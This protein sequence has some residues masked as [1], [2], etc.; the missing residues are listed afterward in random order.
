[1]SENLKKTHLITLSFD[2]G[3]KKSFYKTAEIYEQYGLKA[4]FNVVALGHQPNFSPTI[5]GQ[6]DPGFVRFPKGNFTDW[7]HLKKRGHEVM[8]HT[9]NHVNLTQIPLVEAKELIDKCAD[10]F[11]AHLQGFNVSDSVYSFA[12][13]A[14]NP[15]LDAYTLTKFLAIRTYG[16]TPI[17]PIPTVKEPVRIG[18]SSYGPDNCDEFFEREVNKFLAS[19]GGWF[20]FNTHGLDEEGWGPMSAKY[21]TSLLARLTKLP[22]VEVLPAGEVV[23]RL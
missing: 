21:L 7:N 5:L 10:Y 14:S 17:N 23:T 22:A 6:P 19:E 8:A 11:E 12:Y 15:E 20:V 13:N 18:C 4:C 2:D 16:K 9:Y 1:M 3:F